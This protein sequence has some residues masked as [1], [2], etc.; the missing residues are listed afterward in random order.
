MSAFILHRPLMSLILIILLSN[1]VIYS[2]I[3]FLHTSFPFQRFNYLYNAHR[4]I[5]DPRINSEPFD[6]LKSLTQYDAQWYLKIAAT[7]YPSPPFD[8]DM[9]HKTIMSGLT[10]AYFP[11]YSLL[12]ASVKPLFSNLEFAAFIVSNF[13]ILINIFSLYYTVSRLFTRSLAFK[14]TILVFFFPFSIFFRSY[15]AEGL[16]LFLLIWFTYF[17]IKKKFFYSALFLAFLSI[18]KGNS[19]LLNIVYIYQ[20]F[21]ST[22]DHQIK[23]KHVI[24]LICL[25]TF[26]FILWLGYNY[27]KTA[28]PFFFRHVYSSWLT[29]PYHLYPLLNLVTISRLFFL[30]FHLFH[31][32]FVDT[33]VFIVVGI[34]LLKSR[35]TLPPIYWWTSFLLWFTPFISHDFMSFT[36]YQTVS[37]PLF[38]Y[39]SSLLRKKQ[40]LFISVVFF[41]LL[42]LTSLLFINWYWV[43]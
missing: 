34:L 29:V 31:S 1:L 3:A 12:I 5:A 18:T 16:Q 33:S 21:R 2:A 13:I 15:F 39:L 10:Y 19:L 42:L 26:P 22:A 14:T 6:L 32:S 27:F 9:S 7:G 38:L 23:L 8:L 43:G 17:L 35:K 30:P 41:L 28:D 4:F 24:L 40:F 25:I 37:F 20:L 11:L 36:R